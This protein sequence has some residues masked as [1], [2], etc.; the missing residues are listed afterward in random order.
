MMA[1]LPKIKEEN[2][3]KLLSLV[4]VALLMLCACSL[5]AFADDGTVVYMSFTGSGDNDGL[6]PDT[7]KKGWGDFTGTGVVSLLQGGGTLVAVQKAYMGGSYTLPELGGPLTITGVYNGVDYKNPEP[8]DNPAAGMFK[9]ASGKTFTISGEVIFDDIILFQENNQ[10]TIVVPLGATLTVTDSVV[11]MTKPG[12]DYHFKLMIEMGGTAILSKAAQ[13]TFEIEN[14]GGTVKTYGDENA[15]AVTNAPVVTE[16]PAVTTA[17][18]AV[19]TAAPVV[20]TAAPVVTTA[21]PVET[22]EAP[23]ETTAAPAETTT[24]PAPVAPT[25]TAAPTA[26]AKDGGSNVGVIIGIIAAIVVV[27]AVVVIVIKKKKN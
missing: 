13:D 8:A 11:L 21:A 1:V 2:M 25:T 12:N 24:A 26:P 17:A 23:A 19:T 7:P 5:T 16:A 15:P 22:T 14:L 10:N 4:L 3:K 9:M 20:T 27:A 18:P 6:T